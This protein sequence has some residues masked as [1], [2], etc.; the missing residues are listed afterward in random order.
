MR[1][2]RPVH[3]ALAALVSSEAL[4]ALATLAL[5]AALLAPLGAHA[6]EAAARPGSA[7]SQPKPA[8][9]D[10]SGRRQ[11]GKASFYAKRFAGRKMADGKPMNPHDD[12]AASKTL[13]LGTKAKVTNLATGRSATVTIQ[14]R[15]PYVKGRIVDL[16]PSTA[17]QIGIT[18]KSGVA[19]VEVAPIAV[20]QP[21]GSVKPGAAAPSR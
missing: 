5:G 19:P 21:D 9:P 15:G 14:D 16:S 6:G 10:L 17:Q 13:P 11:L 7:A 12:N 2:R 3:A 8:K 4:A 1:E 18:P 20:P